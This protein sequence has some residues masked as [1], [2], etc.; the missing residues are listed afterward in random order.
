MCLICWTLLRQQISQGR[1]VVNG[2]I[3]SGLTAGEA[4]LVLVDA[5][6]FRHVTLS[7][8]LGAANANIGSLYDIKHLVSRNRQPPNDIHMSVHYH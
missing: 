5:A 6:L 8:V 1:G 3:I 2:R 4:G 7:V